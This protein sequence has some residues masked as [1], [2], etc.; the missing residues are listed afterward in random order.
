MLYTKF[1]NDWTTGNKMMGKWSFVRFDSYFILIWFCDE[2]EM[3]F[4]Y[5]VDSQHVSVKY[6]T[7]FDTAQQ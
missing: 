7:V 6:S 4:L 1:Q 2:T 3:D 5:T